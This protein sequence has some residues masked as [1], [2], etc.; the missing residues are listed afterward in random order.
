MVSPSKRSPPAPAFEG[1]FLAPA[2][3]L[4]AA[5]LALIADSAGPTSPSPDGVT[6]GEAY[7]MPPPEGDEGEA[8]AP[9]DGPLNRFP[10]LA[11]EKY[12]Y[13]LYSYS[14]PFQKLTTS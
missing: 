6:A 5:L 3:L 11:R 7:L 4:S 9:V 12:R 10:K 1:A 8:K 2:P 14:P 13:R